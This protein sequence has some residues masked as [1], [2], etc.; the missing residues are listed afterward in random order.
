MTIAADIAALSPTALVELFELDLTP[1]G[2]DVVRFHGGKN[3]LVGNIVFDGNTYSAYP[4][5]ANGF[6][7]N[8]RGKLPRP[9]LR[10]AN[11]TGEITGLVL[12][13]Q[14]LL[15]AKLTRIRTLAKYLD[16][17][18]FPGGVN[19]T[20]DPDQRLPDEIWYIDRKSQENKVVVEFEL[21]ASF[22]VVGVQ[23][24][25]RQI[26]QNV[27]PWEYRGTE[28]GYAGTDYFNTADQPVA[29]ADLDKC[30][31]R[32]TSCRLRFGQAA[33]LPYGGFPAAGLVR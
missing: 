7:L 20:A 14:D 13:Y 11:V 4:I 22:D 18:N 9:T 29:L 27:C 23:L 24:P 1:F 3:S 32:L 19:A 12:D 21:T 5:E 17:V 31:K 6:E 25:R 16:A 10:V 28:C 26:I 15:G 8:G 30:G 2:G 33:A